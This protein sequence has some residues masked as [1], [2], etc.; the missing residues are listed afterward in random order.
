MSLDSVQYLAL[1]DCMMKDGKWR[2]RRLSFVP[3]QESPVENVSQDTIQELPGENVSQDTIE[4][5]LVENVSEDITQEPSLEPPSTPETVPNSPNLRTVSERVP[6]FYVNLNN[7][8]A[9]LSSG[10]FLEP[11]DLIVKFHTWPSRVYIVPGE[12]GAMYWTTNFKRS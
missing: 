2:V 10:S 4:E 9:E 7:S 3:R 8:S 1:A 5:P 11:V 12:Y 6:V